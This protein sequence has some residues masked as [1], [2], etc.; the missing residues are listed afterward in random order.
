MWFT[1]NKIYLSLFI[2]FFIL[3]LWGIISFSVKAQ[4]VSD[5]CARILVGISQD[6]IIWSA[7]P[8]YNFGGFIIYASPDDVSPLVPIDTVFDANAR[9]Y[10]NSNPGE[11]V[12]NYRITIIC[13]GT[14]TA[15][16]GI[17][18]NQRP[19][20]PDI[21]SVS[22]INGNPVLSWNPSPSP[23]VI[24]YQVYKE[25]P[26][27]SSNFFPYPANNQI[28]NGLT[29]TD[30]N[31]NDLLVRY[32]I[33]AISNCNAGLLG[34]GNALDG[35]TG[36]HSSM[37]LESSIDNCSGN[38]TLNWNPYE[39]WEEG[40]DFY[41]IKMKRNGGAANNIDSVSTNSYI[42]PSA[43]NGDLLEFWIEAKEKNQD[44]KAL[45]NIVLMNIDVNKR[46]DYLYLTSVTI[47]AVTQKPLISWRWDVDSDYGSAFLQRST[48]SIN[49]ENVLSIPDNLSE[50][51]S[52]SD[53]SA[54]SDNQ[55]YF[56]RIN[57]TDACG[58]NII[59]NKGRNILLKA[60]ATEAFQNILNWNPFFL[61]FAQVDEY[62][63]HK[64]VGPT[65]LRIVTL[66]ESDSSYVDRANVNNADEAISCYYVEATAVINIPDNPPR[67]SFS[68]SNTVCSEQKAVLWFPNA[69]IPEGK[70]NIFKPLAGFGTSLESY[71]LQIYNRYG[72][73]IFES[74]NVD[75]GWDGTIRSKSAQQGV[76]VY[77]CRFT[78]NDGKSEVIKGTLTLIR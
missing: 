1:S 44:N 20:T 53:P 62:D 18:S 61:E 58:G 22:I 43:Q 12:R 73:L 11:V 35:T 68:R 23:E 9:G 72:S 7:Q 31:S 26:Y 38:I 42:Y 55:S 25:D 50:S 64:I 57:F 21:R 54:D 5:P 30:I 10:R 34:E 41:I 74:N 75:D 60:E 49:W 33:V 2:R 69:F 16:T 6:S 24:G 36:P 48:D 15:S 13:G 19:L 71:N 78:Q 28:V 59:S 14:V 3:F 8:C 40:V 37:F 29:F 46:M 56:Y 66:G 77:V 47:E 63:I 67:F 52:I 45:S 39:N 27:G 32:A 17:V 51:N 76:Y 4:T 70:N 65:D